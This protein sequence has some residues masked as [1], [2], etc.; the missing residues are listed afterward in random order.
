MN[1]VRT[2]LY[3]L[4][5]HCIPAEVII[6]KLTLELFPKLDSNLKS[7][8]VHW[9]AFY[10]HRLQTGSKDIFHLEGFIAKF[11]SIL[12]QLVTPFSF[13]FRYDLP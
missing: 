2:K 8:V 12:L 7:E 5:A 6:T 11:M 10:E 1:E 3:E 13:L 4:L 9:A